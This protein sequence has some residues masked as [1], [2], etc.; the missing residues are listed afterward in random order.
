M[1]RSSHSKRLIGTSFFLTLVASAA[2]LAGAASDSSASRRRSISFE[3][4]GL[5]RSTAASANTA[6]KIAMMTAN[7][8]APLVHFHAAF[9]DL[10]RQQDSRDTQPLEEL[11][12]DAA[13]LERAHDFPVGPNALAN[14]I[15]NVLHAD[16]IALL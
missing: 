13:R 5:S 12:T 1:N 4:S 2:R 3:R 11:R 16:D 15:E 8:R 14:E 10:H 9:E 6:A 7:I